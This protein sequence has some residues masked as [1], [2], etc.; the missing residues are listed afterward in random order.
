MIV[1]WSSHDPFS[2]FLVKYTHTHRHTHTQTHTHTHTTA[3]LMPL[4]F[5][6][7]ENSFCYPVQQTVPELALEQ[8]FVPGPG[9]PVMPQM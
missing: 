9:D 7:G 8:D 4:Y 5:F 2:P 6:F 3:L 1:K